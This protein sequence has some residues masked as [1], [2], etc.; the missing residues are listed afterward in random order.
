MSARGSMVAAALALLAGL[1]ACAPSRTYL[2]AS[3]PP[4]HAASERL[5]E[6]PGFVVVPAI[7][8]RPRA[9]RAGDSPEVGFLF[10]SSGGAMSRTTGAAVLGGDHGLGWSDRGVAGLPS[11]ASASVAADLGAALKSASG[12]PVAFT[13]GSP[14]AAAA[15]AADGTVMVAVVI[16]HIAKITPSNLDFSQTKSQ[17]GNYEVTTT[18]TQ[19]ESFGS[20]W[21]FSF[22][23]QLGQVRGGRVVRRL[24]RY[25]SASSPSV[26]GYDDAI[27]AAA[28]RVVETVAR[29]WSVAGVSVQGSP[30]HAQ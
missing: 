4:L 27:G 3:P 24:L 11:S 30:D 15:S 19:S 29:E 6:V 14:D 22:R 21:T 20:F 10:A 2:S 8:G 5:A 18:T 16:D 25:A 26:S 12:R 9:E 17:Q 28:Y 7:D 13:P 23:I 1:G